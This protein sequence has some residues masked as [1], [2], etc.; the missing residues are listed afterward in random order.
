MVSG[1]GPKKAGAR[2]LPLCC[3]RHCR[4]KRLLHCRPKTETHRHTRTK[5]ETHKADV[6]PARLQTGKNGLPSVA[7]GIPPLLCD[8]HEARGDISPAPVGGRRDS[9][10]AG[11]NGW[12]CTR[13]PSSFH[14]VSVTVSVQFPLQFPLGK[15]TLSSHLLKNNR[16][17]ILGTL[18][19]LKRVAE[20]ASF[21]QWRL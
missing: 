7:G 16:V 18:S 8:H 21:Y 3:E 6:R 2:M 9:Q 13:L 5:T 1:K 19:F 11:V 15:I 12:A 17:P 10:R 14:S 20:S 4:R